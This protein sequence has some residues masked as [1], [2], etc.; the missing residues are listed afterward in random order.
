MPGR[1]ENT[2]TKGFTLMSN[3]LRRILSLIIGVALALCVCCAGAAFAAE[4][5][6]TEQPTEQAAQPDTEQPAE[7]AAQ[8][9]TEQP[10][11]QPDAGQ[12]AAELNDIEDITA[13]VTVNGENVHFPDQQPIILNSRTYI[14]VRFVADALIASVDWAQEEEIVTITRENMSLTLQIGNARMTVDTGD[15]PS[16]VDMDVAPILLND[17]TLLPIRYVAEALGGRV[18]WDAENFVVTIVDEYVRNYHFINNERYVRD[19]GIYVNYLR[20][21][22]FDELFVLDEFSEFYEITA[23]IIDLY[24]RGSFDLML[25][26]TDMEYLGI[27]GYLNFSALLGIEDGSVVKL[28]EGFSGGGSMG[29]DALCFKYDTLEKRHYVFLE[30]MY[31]DGIFSY[32]GFRHAYGFKDGV[33]G[34]VRKLS[35][36][37]FL[38][39]DEFFYYQDMIDEVK[40][41]TDLYYTNDD[42]FLWAYKIDDVYVSED[43]YMEYYDRL[44]EPVDMKYAMVPV[45]FEDPVP[46]LP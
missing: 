12:P 1:G 23:C 24:N 36:E 28:A 31:R 37:R 42:D 30:G 7:Q 10:A 26:I 39:D 34:T 38:L 20:D 2:T 21:G 15:G 32:F 40:A 5:P 14:P 27:T 3:N 22:G 18:R 35:C 11:A 8:P 9:D 43:E 33:F 4:Q 17:R 16:H 19:R 13:L 41:E 46:P 25:T 6:A 44:T 29:G 45:T